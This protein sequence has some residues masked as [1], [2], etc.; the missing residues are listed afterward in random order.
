V[1]IIIIIII[2]ILCDYPLVNCKRVMGDYCWCSSYL[3]NCSR[4][5]CPSKSEKSFYWKL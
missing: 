3:S 5:T 1:T 4:I 2:I